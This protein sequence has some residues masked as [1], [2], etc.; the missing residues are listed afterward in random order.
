MTRGFPFCAM[1]D[2]H[3]GP[4]EVDITLSISRPC[5]QGADQKF[6]LRTN[7]AEAQA[8]MRKT[9][10]RRVAPDTL[11]AIRISFLGVAR[12]SGARRFADPPALIIP[13]TGIDGRGVVARRRF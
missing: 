13:T 8:L 5:A 9:L 6:G 11:A 7:P 4:Y 2:H 3:A 1:A 10:T 12:G